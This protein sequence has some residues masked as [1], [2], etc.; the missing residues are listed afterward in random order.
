MYGPPLAAPIYPSYGGAPVVQQQQRTI[1][2]F[3]TDGSAASL[4]KPMFDGWN[5]TVNNINAERQYRKMLEIQQEYPQTQR[6][7]IQHR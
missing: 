3:N 7:I 6:L 4:V 1:P 5:Q 2:D